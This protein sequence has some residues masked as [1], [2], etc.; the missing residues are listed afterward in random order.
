MAGGA[1]LG[2]G[3]AAA[4]PSQAPTT[5]NDPEVHVPAA[6]PSP[7]VGLAVG[8]AFEGESS[9]ARSVA[10]RFVEAVRSSRASALNSLLSDP[11]GRVSPQ[12][13]PQTFSRA[14]VVRQILQSVQRAGLGPNVALERLVDLQRADAVPVERHHTGPL[15]SGYRRGD[16]LVSFPLTPD[17]TRLFQGVG[18]SSRGRLVVRLGPTAEVL[19]L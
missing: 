9:Q 7:T 13:T 1:L 18:W 8:A 11:V 6:D 14:A 10:L 4:P 16:V 17:G 5:A 19:A 15:P 3:S 2:C 12:L